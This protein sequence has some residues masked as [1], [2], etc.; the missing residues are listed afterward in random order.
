MIFNDASE[1][2]KFMF[3]ASKNF[4]VNLFSNN[5]VQMKNFETNNVFL[6]YRGNSQLSYLIRLDQVH[7]V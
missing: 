4:T 1:I 3:L 6:K 7:V 2:P 5:V